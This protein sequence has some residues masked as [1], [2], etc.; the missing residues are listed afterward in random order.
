[1]VWWVV[2]SAGEMVDLVGSL[3]C[4]VDGRLLGCPVG[5]LVGN[6]LLA[7]QNDGLLVGYWVV[8]SVEKSVVWLVETLVGMKVAMLAVD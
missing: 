1:M 8:H 5:C 2:K 4:G 6:N 7:V 3:E